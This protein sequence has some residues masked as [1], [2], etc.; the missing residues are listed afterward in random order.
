MDETQVQKDPI[1][2]STIKE[3]S[4]S[5]NEDPIVQMKYF[6]A[7]KLKI[8]WNHHSYFWKKYSFNF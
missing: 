4:E 7:M 5:I 8:V 1:I 3:N 6:A 2:D